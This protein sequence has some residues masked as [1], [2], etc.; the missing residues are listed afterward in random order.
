MAS[1]PADRVRL[2]SKGRLALGYDADLAIFGA[3]DAYVVDAA[4]LHHKNPLTPYHGKTRL[5][6]GAQDLRSR[7]GSG[8]SDPA[9]PADQPRHGLIAGHAIRSGS[10][11]A[12]NRV[13]S[14]SKD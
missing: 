5:R 6:P 7:P 2:R 12:V 14:L 10:P 1:K 9:R 13:L 11:D 4:K 8:L 3:D